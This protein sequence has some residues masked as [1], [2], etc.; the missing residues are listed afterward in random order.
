MKLEKRRDKRDEDEKKKT[1]LKKAYGKHG[2]W[3]Q[4][5]RKNVRMG[6]G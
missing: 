3:T 4:S 2:Q 1:K 6:M 5:R